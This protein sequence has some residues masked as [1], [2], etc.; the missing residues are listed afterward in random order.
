M[1]IDLAES[2]D[3]TTVGTAVVGAIALALE[4]KSVAV[5]RFTREQ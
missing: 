3:G 4:K 2:G 5:N 1:P